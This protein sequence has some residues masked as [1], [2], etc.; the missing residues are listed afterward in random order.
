M[1]D[2]T[3]EATEPADTDL[4]VTEAAEVTEPADTDAQD[5]TDP[6]AD[7]QDRDAA[8]YRRR[9][10]DTEAERDTLA[11]QV[12]ALQRAAIDAQAEAQAIKPA[13]LWASGVQL[14]DLLTDDG[15]VDP[16]KVTAA[17]VTARDTLGLGPSSRNHVPS[18][19][20]NPATAA[21]GRDGMLD[22]VMGR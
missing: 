20:R 1:T 5:D 6:F 2:T 16:S 22:V 17:C 9:L 19:G 13:A 10:R 12:E 14:A 7:R 21:A 8:K 18:E 4:D 15:T 11:A 3:T